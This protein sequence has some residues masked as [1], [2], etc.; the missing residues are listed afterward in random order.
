[1]FQTLLTNIKVFSTNHHNCKCP[2]QATT[3]SGL[4]DF[5]A[6]DCKNCWGKGVLLA[7]AANG[8]L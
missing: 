8:N 6:V 2:T 3:M 4:A 7:A 1:M 5:D